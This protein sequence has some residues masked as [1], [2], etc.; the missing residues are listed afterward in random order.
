MRQFYQQSLP[1]ATLHGFQQLRIVLAV[2]GMDGV[3]TA[4]QTTDSQ[5]LQVERAGYMVEYWLR[6][7]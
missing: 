2:F 5:R 3:A 1:I 7:L 4:N 6:I